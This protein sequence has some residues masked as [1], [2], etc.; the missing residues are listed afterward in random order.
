MSVLRIHAIGD[1]GSFGVAGVM[2][3]QRYWGIRRDR[4]DPFERPNC[5]GCLRRLGIKVVPSLT[6][7]RPVQIALFQGAS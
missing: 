3:H 4:F 6:Y 1:A 5:K 7:R 2:C